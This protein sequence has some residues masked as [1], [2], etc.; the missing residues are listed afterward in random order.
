MKI[1][2]E[3]QTIQ[4]PV[5]FNQFLLWGASLW[6]TDFIYGI[7]VYT[8]HETKI[9]KNTKSSY[10]KSKLERKTGKYIIILFLVQLILCIGA[11]L[12]NAIIDVRLQSETDSY[13]FWSFHK[14]KETTNFWYKMLVSSGTWILILNDFVPI[15]LLVTSEMVK[16]WQA[17]FISTDIWM[18]DDNLQ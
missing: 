13:M 12:T 17:F 7:V 6:N 10:K 5:D 1:L 9:M 16:F 11:S 14:S 2:S 3:E 4:I 15:S 8:G 18:Y